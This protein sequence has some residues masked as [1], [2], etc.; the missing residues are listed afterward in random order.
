MSG[1][2]SIPEDFYISVQDYFIDV[3]I[4]KYPSGAI[5]VTNEDGMPYV[6]RIPYM[7]NFDISMGVLDINANQEAAI[8]KLTYLDVKIHGRQIKLAF[9]ARDL[10]RSGQDLISA[11]N[12]TIIAKF[13]DELDEAIWHGSYEGAVKTG[14]GLI[15]QLTD[16]ASGITEAQAT[17]EIVFQNMKHCVQSIAAKYRSLY[18][19]ALVIDWKSYDRVSTGIATGFTMTALDVFK[20]AFPSVTIFVSDTIL[21]TA[22]HIS[23]GT[24]VVGT[25]GR[26]L[27]FAQ[28]PDL[29]RNI[30]VKA[31]SPGG[32]AIVNLAGDIEQIWDAYW[33]IKVIESTATAYTGTVL[34]F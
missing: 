33:G 6:S 2:Y 24:D 21:A 19:I 32:P 3:L 7:E 11:K 8:A 18:P 31:P 34:T 1:V 9:T 17:A 15:E 29:V 10:R 26:M 23:G 22:A 25:N 4:E 20:S 16:V 5:P 28:N 14:T 27:A 12:K 30:M 13:L